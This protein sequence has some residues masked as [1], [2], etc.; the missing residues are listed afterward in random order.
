MVVPSL[1]S[2]LSSSLLCRR[3]GGFAV[4]CGFWLGSVLKD[5]GIWVFLFLFGG[6]VGVLWV[7]ALEKGRRETEGEGRD[8]RKCV[9]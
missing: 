4:V 5:F 2:P 9:D 7:L 3:G 8:W 1:I 6:Y